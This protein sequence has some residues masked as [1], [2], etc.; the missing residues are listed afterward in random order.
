MIDDIVVTNITAKLIA[1]AGLVCLEIAIKEQSPK[2]R[3]SMTLYIN[4]AEIK[5]V[6]NP[7]ASMLALPPLTSSYELSGSSV[8]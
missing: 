3:E 5:I 8:F 7:A 2:K 1:R 6:K 4:T